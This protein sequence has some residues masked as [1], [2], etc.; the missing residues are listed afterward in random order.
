MYFRNNPFLIH[1]FTT[2]MN[3]FLVVCYSSNLNYQSFNHNLV[4]PIH[5]V[6][7]WFSS[8][9][10]VNM[11]VS[12]KLLLL[13]V[14]HLFSVHLRSHY[15]RAYKANARTKVALRVKTMLLWMQAIHPFLRQMHLPYR[16]ETGYR[17]YHVLWYVLYVISYFKDIDIR[18]K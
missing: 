7:L 5:T 13:N 16:V 1:V 12:V 4:A 2:R 10:M 9:Y 8:C 3:H 11:G 14:L 6:Y 17:Q 18:G 15:L